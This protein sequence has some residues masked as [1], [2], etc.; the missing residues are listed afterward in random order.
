MTRR[1]LSEK[2]LERLLH[3]GSDSEDKNQRFE[4]NLNKV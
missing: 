2:E 1:G 3:E 4:N